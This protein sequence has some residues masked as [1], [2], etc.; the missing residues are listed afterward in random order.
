[1]CL[2]DQTRVEE[3]V[4]KRVR[5]F[6]FSDR[7][8]HD[9]LF[10]ARMLLVLISALKR[11]LLHN[12]VVETA[13]EGPDVNCGGHLALIV[14]LALLGK[15]FRRRKR[16]VASKI[17]TFEQFKIVVGE[18]DEVEDRFPVV[19]VEARRV[20]IPVDKAMVVHVSHCARDLP[21]N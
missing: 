8:A 2:V 21:E 20:D 14:E 7:H 12:E 4:D 13:A 5:D 6:H 16:E 15:E 19:P 3:L 11:V 18:P 17:F 1:M 9:V 10:R